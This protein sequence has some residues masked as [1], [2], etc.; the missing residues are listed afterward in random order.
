MK[1]EGNVNR[2]DTSLLIQCE[3]E[4]FPGGMIIG[5]KLNKGL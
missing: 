2:Q 5:L 3:Q 1:W 4:H